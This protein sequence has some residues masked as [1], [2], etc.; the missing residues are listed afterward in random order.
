MCARRTP[1]GKRLAMADNT[2]IP[3]PASDIRDSI[4]ATRSLALNQTTLGEEQFHFLQQIFPHQRDFV[5]SECGKLSP[6][7]LPLTFSGTFAQLSPWTKVRAE[8]CLFDTGEG[9]HVVIRISRPEADTAY[10]YLS[11]YSVDP[12]EPISP[13]E[14]A[15]TTGLGSCVQ[16]ISFSPAASHMVFST[17]D[18]TAK[19]A[20]QSVY[21]DAWKAEFPVRHVNKGLNFSADITLGEGLHGSLQ[22]MLHGFD[23]AAPKHRCLI[24]GDEYGPRF[25]LTR[26]LTGSLTIAPLR[27]NLTGTSIGLPLARPLGAPLWPHILVEGTVI[28]DTIAVE[29]TAALHT[30]FP[31]LSLSFTGFPSLGQLITHVGLSLNSLPV[32]LSQMLDVT[33]STLTI[34]LNLNEKSVS[35]ISFSLTTKGD[36]DLIKDVISLKPTLTMQIYF[37]LD[38]EWRSIE[39]SLKGHWTFEGITFNAELAYPSLQ[40]YAGMDKP[41]STKRLLQRL[42][43]GID[44][45]EL[46][47]TKMEIE[48]NVLAKSFWARI[49]AEIGS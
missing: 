45:P 8:V 6:G 49:E 10:A 48:G 4:N 32:P 15:P 9:R 26:A 18:Y 27:L 43:P 5:V 36:I 17:L 1:P 35:E 38:A 7:N 24:S 47:F 13:D 46:S 2:A 19:G 20:D 30:Y 33:L 41:V 16:E 29:V 12:G 21:P 11:Q 40:F 39:G 42:L 22:F 37:P 44:L 23:N 31:E 28:V 34:V 25:R 14:V 3:S